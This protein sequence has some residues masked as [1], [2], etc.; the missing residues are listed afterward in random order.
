MIGRYGFLTCF[1]GLVAISLNCVVGFAADTLSSGSGDSTDAAQRILASRCFAC[2]GPSKQEGELRLDQAATALKGG[3]EGVVIRP[4]HAEESL[5]IEY[6]SGTGDTVMPP[7]GPRL[8]APEVATLK[9][10]INDGAKWPAAQ[11]GTGIDPRL[12]HWSFQPVRRVEPPAVKN[13][14]WGR[15][16][17]D[18]FILA[19]LEQENVTPSPEADR[20]TLIRRL[21]FDLLGLPP[22]TAEVDDFLADRRPDAYERLVD[23]LLASPH[24]GERWGRHWLDRARFAE[25]SGC[26]IDLERPFAWRW[27]DWVIGAINNDLPFDQFTI[28]QI[29]GDLLPNATTE[30][31][32]ATGF[33]ENALTNHEAGIDLEAE[34][35]KTTLDRTTA[36]GTAWL[37]LTVGCAQCHSHK[38]DPISQRDFYSLYAFFDSLEDRLIDAPPIEQHQQLNNAKRDLLLARHAYLSMPAA[39]QRAWEEAIAAKRTNTWQPATE[40]ESISFRSS[41]HAMIHQLADDS[42]FVDGRVRDS[43]TY[44]IAFKSPV[45]K[46]SAIRIEVLCDPDRFEHG[47]GRGADQRAV[48]SGITIQTGPSDKSMPTAKAE[49]ASS[50]ADYCQSGYAVADAVRCGEATGWSLD[51]VG[52]PHAAV[53]EL[54]EPVLIADGGRVI[55]RLDQQTGKGHVFER[56]RISV[57]GNDWKSAGGSSTLEKPVPDSIRDLAC[58]PVARR[59]AN[60]QAQLKRYYQ[61]VFQSGSP[62]LAAWNDAL[63]NFAKWQSSIAAQTVRDRATPRET[64]VHVRGDFRRPGEKVEPAILPA[65]CKS[66]PKNRRLT[67]LDLAEWIASPDNPLTARVAANDIWQHLFGT[68]LVD[69][70]GDFGMQGD[71][72]SHPELLDWLASEY[73]RCGWSR[74]AM[75]RRIVCSATYRQSSAT[76]SD[77]ADRDPKNRWLA[78]QTRFRL[79]AE[80]VRDAVL[81]CSGLLD[82]RIGGRSFQVT[83]STDDALEGWEP[84][85]APQAPH[86]IYRRGLYVFAKRTDADPLL[87]AFDGTDGMTSCPMRRRTNTPIQSLTLLNDPISV[88]ATRA[89]ARTFDA[90][91]DSDCADWIAGVFNRCT[92]RE[93]KPFELKTLTKLFETVRDEYKTHPEEAARLVQVDPNAKSAAELAAAFVVSRTI[94]NLDEVVTRE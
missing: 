32:V 22:T 13:K 50:V 11:A 2:H 47:P 23:R 38:Y 1:A 30:T 27:R 33:H 88:T 58:R 14:S 68:G 5:L 85:L 89:L 42:L 48:L 67:R 39:G 76:R 54:R 6:V 28:E 34:R 21:S 37:G 63:A 25:S 44:V 56:F 57:A 74:K 18:A 4:G 52:L 46:L 71:P 64:F 78:R 91:D 75:I 79:E 70:P 8:T 92:S 19:K 65:L 59:T 12:R 81:S 62:E 45:K 93:P 15:N 36:V 35:V 40:L 60:E 82:E 94:L 87:I 72:P 61:S 66:T 16:E 77:L 86:D 90:S 31:R 69:T 55:V 80:A 10:W 49:I 83:R 17:I 7:K 26:V 73:V 9:A 29:A 51:Q 84:D 3:E 20:R 41:R 53:F 24:F 43:D